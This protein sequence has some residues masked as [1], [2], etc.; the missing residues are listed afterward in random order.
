LFI[1]GQR[2]GSQIIQHTSA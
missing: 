1:L 2:S